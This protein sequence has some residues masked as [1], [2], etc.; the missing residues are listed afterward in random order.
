M[1]EDPRA[2]A[3][4]DE[5]IR[6]ADPCHGQLPHSVAGKT[7]AGGR[8][9]TRQGVALTT[10]TPGLHC[11]G[12]HLQEWLTPIHRA[13]PAVIADV[14]HIRNR[15]GPY[16]TFRSYGPVQAHL[17]DATG[18]PDVKPQAEPWLPSAA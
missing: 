1:P 3:A 7:A 13:D 8:H 15:T 2:R 9:S 18:N 6:A 11:R 10:L 5:L 14:R 17:P 16:C 12:T 4:T